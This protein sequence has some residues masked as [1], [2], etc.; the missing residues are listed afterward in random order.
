MR[1]EYIYSAQ[2]DTIRIRVMTR[3]SIGAE[4]PN[5]SREWDYDIFRKGAE[6]V[7]TFSGENGDVCYS[8]K[9]AVEDLKR[10]FGK[11][12]SINPEN[13]VTEGW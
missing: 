1:G 5:A 10:R 2:N 8:K 7:E 12:K 13:T 4:N 9:E 3:A 11:L 6:G